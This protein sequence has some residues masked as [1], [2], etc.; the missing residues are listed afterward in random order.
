MAETPPAV[1][2][3]GTCFCLVVTAAVRLSFPV[4]RSVIAVI[5]IFAGQKGALVRLAPSASCDA[6]QSAISPSIPPST[7]VGPS[8]LKISVLTVPV[9]HSC[10][11]S[12]GH[13]SYS[14][15]DGTAIISRHDA[16]L[17]APCRRWL[18]RIQKLSCSNRSSSRSDRSIFLHRSPRSLERRLSAKINQKMKS[19][20]TPSTF[21]S[22]VITRNNHRA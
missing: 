3:Y 16:R 14:R 21:I 19:P 10:T 1:S 12:Q 13:N 11:R 18:A 20:M 9:G 2:S 15:R 5:G 22:S 8:A 6:H 17:Q 7:T 4:D